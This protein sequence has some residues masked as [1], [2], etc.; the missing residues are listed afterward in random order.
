MDA[1]DWYLPDRLVFSP[2]GKYFKKIRIS[3]ITSESASSHHEKALP[4]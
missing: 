2:L 1:Q 3:P 4:L